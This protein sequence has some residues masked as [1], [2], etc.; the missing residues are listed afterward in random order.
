MA[1]GFRSFT[2]RYGFAISHIDV[3][4]V[5][6]YAYSAVRVAGVP[7]SDR[8]PPPAPVHA[9]RQ[10]PAYPNCGG[11]IVPLASHCRCDRGAP[12]STDWFA[13]LRPRAPRRRSGRSSPS[14]RRRSTD[15]ELS[16]HLVTVRRRAPKRPARAL[17]ARRRSR[18]AGRAATSSARPTRGTV[19]HR[20]VG[21]P[22]RRR[23]ALDGGDRAGARCDRGRTPQR[24][25]G[26]PSSF[27]DVR[28]VSP[29]MRRRAR[30]VS[31]TSTDNASSV[32]ST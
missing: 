8:P 30:L 27:A 31:R 6:G 3:A 23:R 15:A 19:R 1:E 14:I 22:A 10:P 4:Y 28:N 11:G 5:N 32:P 17:R 16:D 2:A 7:I 20:L 26:E 9:G 24:R 12:I 13:E 29:R 25:C 21:R 18:P